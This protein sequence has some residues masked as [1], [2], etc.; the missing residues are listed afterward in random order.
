MMEEQFRVVEIFQSINGEGT[1]AGQLAVFVRFQGCNLSCSYCDTAWANQADAPVT[2]MTAEQIYQ[3][4]KETGIRNVTLTGGEPL[5]QKGIKQ[6]LLLLSE[7]ETLSV[8]IETNGSV[9]LKPFAQMENRP[10]FTM[11]YKLPGSGMEARMRIENFEYLSEKD[12]VKFVTGTK[13]LE[14]IRQIIEEFS[15]VERCQVILSPVFGE[16]EP[17]ELVEFLLKY[18][19]NHV[20]MQLQ[21]H[22]LIWDSQA[23][24]V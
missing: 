16:I 4:V 6:L 7:D 3:A 21:L 18:K 23:R 13:D 10:L 5:L 2:Q 8:E 15:L 19:Y 20:R 12:T 11:D 14:R 17:V 22:K 24:G 9:D 1:R